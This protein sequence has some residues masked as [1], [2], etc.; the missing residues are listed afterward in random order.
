MA[1]VTL[2]GEKRP[3][4]TLYAT[5]SK[6]AGRVCVQ[7]KGCVALVL[8]AAWDTSVPWLDMT[9][10]VAIH[11]RHLVASLSESALWMRRLTRAYARA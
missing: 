2:E 11:P 9:V 8:V 10:H 7:A 5:L 1:H 3:H 4:D 6:D